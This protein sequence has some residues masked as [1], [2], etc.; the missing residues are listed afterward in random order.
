M[1]DQIINTETDVNEDAVSLAQAEESGAIAVPAPTDG[2]IF[3]VETDPGDNFSIEGLTRDALDSGLIKLVHSTDDPTDLLVFFYD[4]TGAETGQVVLENFMVM[5]Q[6]EAPSVL[7]LEDSSV[8]EQSEFGDLIG[9]YDAEAVATA[10]GGDSGGNSAGGGA[11]YDPHDPGGLGDVDHRLGNPVGD[12]DPNAPEYPE[13][14]TEDPLPE[15]EPEAPAAAAPTVE[16]EEE[17]EIDTNPD[18]VS[19]DV[20]E[21]AITDVA[22]GTLHDENGAQLVDFGTD[23]FGGFQLSTDTSQLASLTAGGEAVVFSVSDDQQTLTA[24]TSQGVVFTFQLEQDG[25][26]T[27]TFLGALDHPDATAD[28]IINFD[29][30][31]IIQAYDGAGDTITLDDGQFSVDLGDDVPSFNTV[32]ATQHVDESDGLGSYSST[33]LFDYGA[34]GGVLELSAD[35]AAWDGEN[36]LLTAND[37]TWSLTIDQATGNYTFTQL[38]VISHSD[39]TDHNE[40]FVVNINAKITDGDS[41]VATTS[42]S[43]TINDDGPELTGETELVVADTS[44]LW[45]EEA[46]IVE[47]DLKHLL[48]TGADIQADGDG[49]YNMLTDTSGLPE[50]YS[51]GH[52]LEYSVSNNVLTA[53]VTGYGDVAF[54]LELDQNSGEYTYTQ[55]YNVDNYEYGEPQA[56]DGLSGTQ[57]FDDF[58]V[59][60]D[61]TSIIQF[62][63]TDG[64]TVNLS[65]LRTNQFVITLD[66]VFWATGDS[67]EISSLGVMPPTDGGESP[68]ELSGLYAAAGMEEGGNDASEGEHLTGGAGNDVLTGGAGNDVLDGGAGDD[69]LT[70]GEGQDTFLFNDATGHDLIKDMVANEDTIDLDAVF[71][72][73]MG[74]GNHDRSVVAT[75]DGDDLTLNLADGDGE[76]IAEAEFSVT[77]EGW[78]NASEDEV[79]AMINKIVVDES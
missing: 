77:L 26:Y 40:A 48:D 78:G 67:A 30:S 54:T 36:G 56:Q 59:E 3:S 22:T 62:E 73:F 71:D 31:S 15:E 45:R 12:P 49:L 42:F 74:D 23:G 75:R 29:L 61:F 14:Q 8:I 6:G 43:L 46:M 68:E 7:S 38:A 76:A 28:D 20:D 41:D 65:D 10:A 64:D 53:T 63:D 72:A 70:G 50:L 4:E 11:G 44:P 25:T 60:I 79:D 33:L 24:S 27:F 34:D 51:W 52:P 17:I 47:G 57:F 69:V 37:G 66:N 55:Y 19:V 5:A 35:N 18:T 2:E 58:M 32:T 16:V 21:S 9:G 13:Q 1:A 39:P